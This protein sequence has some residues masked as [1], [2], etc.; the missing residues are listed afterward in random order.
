[1]KNPALQ[2]LSEVHSEKK[3]WYKDGLKFSCTQCGKCCTGR[4]GYTWVSLDEIEAIAQFLQISPNE[5][6]SKY[7]RKIEGK[8]ALLENSSTFDCV[9]LKDKKCSIYEVRPHQCRTFPWWLQNLQSEEDW[10]KAKSFC[11]GIN[12]EAPLVSFQEISEN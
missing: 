9:F 5:V 4:P 2:V 1:M 6:V 10:Q 7:L 12:E 11:E 3:P 8:W